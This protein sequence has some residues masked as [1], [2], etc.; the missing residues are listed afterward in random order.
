MKL[1]MQRSPQQIA[2][3]GLSQRV[4][5]KAEELGDAEKPDCDNVDFEDVLGSSDD[6]ETDFCDDM[7][8]SATSIGCAGGLSD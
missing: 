1:N 7:Q 6:D 5:S 2:Y 8:E 3:M 4:L